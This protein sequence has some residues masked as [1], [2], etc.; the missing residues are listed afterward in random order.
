MANNVKVKTNSLDELSNSFKNSSIN[1]N[2]ILDYLIDS[3]MNMEDFFETPTARIMKD[4]LITYLK[5]SKITCNN[6]DELGNTIIKSK[7]YYEEFIDKA[8][9]T[10]G[11]NDGV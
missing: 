7:E 3:T 9:D 1:L 4:S 8:S 11:G 10:V 5:D 6:L 2:N